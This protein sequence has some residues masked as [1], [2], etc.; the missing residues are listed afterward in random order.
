MAKRGRPRKVKEVSTSKEEITKEEISTDE[1][2]E[3]LEED[4]RVTETIAND[5][6]NV[7]NP[8]ED[9]GGTAGSYNPFNENVIERDYSTP[10]VAE[11]VTEEIHEPQFVPPSYEDIISER[12]RGE[13]EDLGNPF[14]NPNP[15]LNDLDH[16]D[17]KIACE[18][19]VDTCLDGYEQLHKIAVY[20]AKVDEDDLMQRQIKGKLDLNQEIPVAEDGTT[21]SVSEFVGQYNE[22][23]EEALKYDKEFGY[24]VR[25]AMIRVFMKN[26]W[27]MSDGQYLAYMFGRDVV[28]KGTILFSLKKTMNSTLALLEQTYKQQ[29]QQETDFIPSEP[30]PDDPEPTPTMTTSE[31]ITEPMPE[32]VME[33]V[34]DVSTSFEI[35][36]PQ[37]P[38]DNLKEHPPEIKKQLKKKKKK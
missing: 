33:T 15:A 35:N 13:E 22:Q 19:L 7:E 17:K 1:D 14:D 30:I 29:K 27:G 8:S 12:S 16:A 38:K 34:S 5:K 3:V 31:P 37:N 2:V 21:M 11:G 4:D 32:P 10:K 28:T 20:Y 36:Y 26:G 23:C 24:K 9:L 6:T 25:P 18:S